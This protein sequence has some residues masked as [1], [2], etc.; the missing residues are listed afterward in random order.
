MLTISTPSCR[1]IHD[2]HAGIAYSINFIEVRWCI[3]YLYILRYLEQHLQRCIVL[4]ELFDHELILVL[5][6]TFVVTD[7]REGQ[8][9]T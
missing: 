2:G 5:F 9:A 8:W 6:Q 3:C 4:V 1:Q 7:S